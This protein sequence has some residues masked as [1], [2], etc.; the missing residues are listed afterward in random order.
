MG[1]LEPR[2]EPCAEDRQVAREQPGG[3]CG[4]GPSG[5]LHSGS[6]VRHGSRLTT[7]RPRSSLSSVD[8]G[9]L[10]N[11]MKLISALR[12]VSKRGGLPRWRGYPGNLD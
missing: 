6:A 11:I 12:P 7:T 1:W 3:A 8:G 4:L 5:T 9:H 2:G 10:G